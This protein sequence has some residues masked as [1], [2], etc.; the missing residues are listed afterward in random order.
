MSAKKEKTTGKMCGM[1]NMRKYKDAIIWG[2][3]QAKQPLP[4]SFYDGINSFLRSFKKETK[5]AGE[6]GYLDKQQ[7][8]SISWALYVAILKWSV[9]EK[10]LFLWYFT[11]MQWNCM[12]RPINIGSLSADNFAWGDDYICLKYDKTKMDQCGEK[13][14]NNVVFFSFFVH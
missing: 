5:K 10:N 7:A 1:S 6:K 14:S 12:A 2:L 8:D 9:K 4:P 13:V 3:K 11:I